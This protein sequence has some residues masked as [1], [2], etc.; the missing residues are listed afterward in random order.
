M[1]RGFYF[2]GKWVSE[3][4]ML[5]VARALL[6]IRSHLPSKTTITILTG[7]RYSSRDRE[8]LLGILLVIE[9][10]SLPKWRK[11]GRTSSP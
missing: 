5:A 11:C 6:E 1:K 4:F 10:A 8:T 3:S 7:D 2:Y 9:L